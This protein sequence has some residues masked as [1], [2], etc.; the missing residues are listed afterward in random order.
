M[1]YNSAY[2]P[3][4]TDKLWYKD[5]DNIK[6]NTKNMILL[7]LLGS[8]IF[9]TKQKMRLQCENKP[10][11]EPLIQ[12]SLAAASL[13]SSMDSSWITRLLLPGNNCSLKL[14]STCVPLT[15]VSGALRVLGHT[16]ENKQNGP[17]KRNPCIA[18]AEK[19]R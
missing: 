9:I 4:G 5:Q 7:G 19:H 15:G 13:R 1:F 18:Q 3:T 2:V 6:L 10:G 16:P 17:F 12:K 11:F 14:A 8:K